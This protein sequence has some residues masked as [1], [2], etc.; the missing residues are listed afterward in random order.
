MPPVYITEQGTKIRIHNNCIRVER[1]NGADPETVWQ[2]PVSTVSQLVL[3]GNIGITTPA[4][5][6]FLTKQIDVVFLDSHGN[7]R[8]RLQGDAD[9]HVSIR[10]AQY[11]A[12]ENRS[13]T[14]NMVRCIIRA[15]IGHQ[16]DLLERINRDLP[17]VQAD[18]A[19]RIIA[20]ACASLEKKSTVN[21]M[22]GVEGT[23][24][25]AYF[26]GY[27]R[28]FDAGWGFHRRLKNP[29]PDPVN[30]M[31]SF[32]Y[33]LLTQLAVSAAQTAGLDAYAGFLHTESY[34]RPSLG[35]D[36]V[37]EFRPVV[38]EM[39]LGLCRS[40]EITPDSFQSDKESGGCWMSTD[41][42]KT[43]IR[44]FEGRMD[45]RFVHPLTG[46]ALTLRQCMLEQARQV[47]ECC[48]KAPDMPAFTAM[49]FKNAE[50]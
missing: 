47:A 31:L 5:G 7:F 30:A 11:R 4:I 3:S 24:A 28:F 26:S 49:E 14:K 10:R 19:I 40:G 25:A 39:V 15:K 20:G 37:E 13:F 42:R 21:A 16:M 34:N 8:G 17:D 22:R 46:T 44:R 18:S 50:S 33:T 45:E 9:P 12:V 27:R 6:T 48:E 1:E 43:Y 23:S 36:L 41:A 32:G 35:L 29:S 2:A 38:D